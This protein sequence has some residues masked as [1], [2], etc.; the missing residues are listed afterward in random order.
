MPG[1]DLGV[2]EDQELN[3]NRKKK[4]QSL[5]SSCINRRVDMRQDSQLALSDTGEASAWCPL[6]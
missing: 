6:Q 2:I 3:V 4:K 1:R 5:F